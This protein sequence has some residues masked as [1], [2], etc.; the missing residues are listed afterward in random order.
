MTRETR[1]FSGAVELA[2]GAYSL[3]RAVVRARFPVGQLPLNSIKSWNP[4]T[5][6]V[7]HTDGLLSSDWLPVTRIVRHNPHG[8]LHKCDARC[9]HA[10]AGDCECSCGG[11][12]HGIDR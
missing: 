12:F 8:S 10:K 3:P 4:G 7:G 6:L 9:R 1:Y 11:K 5:L 2:G